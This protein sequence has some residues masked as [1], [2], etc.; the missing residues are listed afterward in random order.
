MP[1]MIPE[2]QLLEQML[3]NMSEKSPGLNPR[4][5]TTTVAIAAFSAQTQAAINAHF[6]RYGLSQGRFVVL[7]LLYNAT[8]RDWT[9]ATL[10]EAAQVRRATM[11][12]L[13]KLLERDGWVSRQQN[14]K[15]NR[16]AHIIL[17]DTGR[18][19]LDKILPDHLSRIDAT[20]SA[21]TDDEHTTLLALMEKFG[22]RISTLP[23]ANAPAIPQNGD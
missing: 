2:K 19:K 4:N 9:P 14:A 11:T 17:T 10:A 8:A 22:A 20:L 15:D 18:Q 1:M 12:G 21:L 5:I 16:S 3:A 7:A 6:A 13:L 23:P